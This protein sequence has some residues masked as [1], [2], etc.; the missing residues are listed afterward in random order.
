MKKLLSVLGALGIIGSSAS[1]LVSCGVTA[2]PIT[3]YVNNKKGDDEVA[4]YALPLMKNPIVDIETQLLN[5]ITIS[6]QKPTDDDDAAMLGDAKELSIE[7]N[8]AGDQT[9]FYT[10]DTPETWNAFKNDYHAGGNSLFTDFNLVTTNKVANSEGTQEINIITGK[11]TIESG[12]QETLDSF[13]TGLDDL[14]EKFTSLSDQLKDYNTKILPFGEFKTDANLKL[15][16]KEDSVKNNVSDGEDNEAS[17]LQDLNNLNDW[18]GKDIP[19]EVKVNGED[20]SATLELTTTKQYLFYKELA[21]TVEFETIF[22]SGDN[23]NQYKLD[24]KFKGLNLIYGLAYPGKQTPDNSLY[25]VAAYLAPVGYAFSVKDKSFKTDIY[26]S[27][28]SYKDNFKAEITKVKDNN[29]DFK[30][31]D[32]D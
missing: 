2:T 16:E 17:E 19:V 31:E 27:I 8:I 21:D 12:E 28:L 11:S 20:D 10:A 26:S 1:T 5:L 23:G 29:F 14:G 4:K 9:D 6:D 15:V 30:G 25:D 18:Q 32:K 22:K 24:F 13:I 7:S 3:T